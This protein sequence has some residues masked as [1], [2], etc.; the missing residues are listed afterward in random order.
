MKAAI[1]LLSDVVPIFGFHKRSYITIVSIIGATALLLLWLVKLSASLAPV[2]ALFLLFVNLQIACVDLLAEAK[3]AELMVKNPQTGSDIVSFVWGLVSVGSLIG[4]LISGPIADMGSPRLLYAIALPLAAQVALPALSGWFPE[5]RNPNASLR[6]DKLHA[7]PKLARLSLA[8][9]LGAIMVGTAAAL[10]S[11]VIQ[12]SISVGAA[13]ALAILGCFWLPP[14]LRKA[15]LYLFLNNV[16][17][18]SLSG[19]MDYFFTAKETCIKD[20]PHFT[21]TYYITWANIV[22]SIGSLIG[23]TVFQRFLNGR[24]FRLAFSLGIIVKLFASMFDYIIVKRYNTKLFGISDKTFFMLGDAVISPIVLM[25]D[26]MPAVVLTSK[27]CPPGME[28]SV[29]ALLVSYQNLGGGVASTIGVE[30]INYLNISTTEPCNFDGLPGAIIFGHVIL[31]ALAFPLIFL[32]IPDARMTDD[33]IN[34]DEEGTPTDDFTALP[35]DDEF[36]QEGQRG[37]PGRPSRVIF[38][39]DPSEDKQDKD[40]NDT[41]SPESSTIGKGNKIT[42]ADDKSDQVPLVQFDSNAPRSESIDGADQQP[43]RGDRSTDYT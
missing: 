13:V 12:S 43:S 16:L 35:S 28:A 21:M 8:M 14:T 18:I 3:Y 36:D 9:T 41:P 10:G 29:Y 22:A 15:N 20:G 42:D 39:K 26:L 31:P 17:Y 2:A 40:R 27:V 19:A 11:P 23:V 32:L 5:T 37:S 4:S 33:L 30:V 25:L 7:H 6:R 1:G 24:S 38:K 34:A